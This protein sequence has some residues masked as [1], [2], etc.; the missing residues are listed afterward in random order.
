MWHYLIQLI[1]DN[2]FAL[3][4]EDHSFALFA[5]EARPSER[6]RTRVC[7]HSLQG[8]WSTGTRSRNGRAPHRRQEMHR[9]CSRSFRMCL[10]LDTDFNALLRS[11][12]LPNKNFYYFKTNESAPVIY[13]YRTSTVSSFEYLKCIV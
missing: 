12:K 6:N 11:Q 3:G 13:P 2:N 8:M 9:S 10:S 4:Q 7:I 1:Q 5:G